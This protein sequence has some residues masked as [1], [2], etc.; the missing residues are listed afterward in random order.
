MAII[1]TG[2]NKMVL[3]ISDIWKQSNNS[4]MKTNE[5][6]NMSKQTMVINEP[7]VQRDYLKHFIWR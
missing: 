4:T 3:R 6:R 2:Y 5:V 7:T 1:S